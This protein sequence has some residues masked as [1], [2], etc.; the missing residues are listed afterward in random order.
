M[1]FAP[2]LQLFRKL[3]FGPAPPSGSKGLNMKKLAAFSFLLLWPIDGDADKAGRSID[4]APKEPWKLCAI[5]ENENYLSTCH[6]I[7]NLLRH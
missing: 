5:R 3:D 1:T 6:G 7:P 2:M 4:Y